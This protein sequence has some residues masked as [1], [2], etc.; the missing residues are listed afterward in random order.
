MASL[1]LPGTFFYKRTWAEPAGPPSQRV[2]I[3]RACSRPSIRPQVSWP[4]IVFVCETITHYPIRENIARER[5]VRF[6]RVNLDHLKGRTNESVRAYRLLH[7]GVVAR[8]KAYAGLPACARRA[9][10][11]WGRGLVVSFRAP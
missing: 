11:P 10:V 5:L 3:G 8:E 1:G 6:L 2:E 9:A 7:R 4:G